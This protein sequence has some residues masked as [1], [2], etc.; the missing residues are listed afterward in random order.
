MEPGARSVSYTHLDVYKRQG[1]ASGNDG[2]GTG[3]VTLR[4]RLRLRYGSADALTVTARP[5]RGV[6]ARLRLPISGAAT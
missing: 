5:R 6:V 4:E 1:L 3:L 2:L